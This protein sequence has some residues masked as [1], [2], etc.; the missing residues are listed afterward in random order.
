M[1]QKQCR[2]FRSSGG[3]TA[4]WPVWPLPKHKT[5]M[6]IAILLCIL[7]FPLY[8]IWRCL[9]QIM[10]TQMVTKSEYAGN[11][12]G[13]RKTQLC[14]FY[15]NN[16]HASPRTLQAPNP[17]P[18]GRAAAGAPALPSTAA[19]CSSQRTATPRPS[20]RPPGPPA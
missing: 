6:L 8:N 9:V 1:M 19:R 3:T 7:G 11:G 2:Y 4:L 15:Q 5:G 12:N 16:S 13:M 17:N 18:K 20:R 10:V 14:L